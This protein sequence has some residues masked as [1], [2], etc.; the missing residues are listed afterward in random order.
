M[1][2]LGGAYELHRQIPGERFL[3]TPESELLHALTAF[4]RCRIT[5]TQNGIPAF[6]PKRLH[7]MFA[8]A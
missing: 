4:D 8:L 3:I 2:S 1:G 5:A 6:Q 7:V